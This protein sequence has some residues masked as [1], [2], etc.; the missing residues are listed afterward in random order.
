[1]KTNILCRSHPV[2]FCRPTWH[3]S[4]LSVVVLIILSAPIQADAADCAPAPAGMVAW[5]PG[6]GNADDIAS[7]NHGMLKNGAILAAGM[8]GQAFIFDGIGSYVQL[9][10]L[11]PGQAEG[12]VECW[13]KLN[14][15][16]WSSARDGVYL[17][18]STEYLPD[19]PNSFDGVNLGTHRGYTSTG[20]ELMFGVWDVNADWKWAMSGVI[21]QMGRWYHVAGTWGPNGVQ[22]YVDGVQRGINPYLGAAPTYLQ[23]SLLGR[24]SHPTSVTDGLIDEFA[25]FSRALSADEIAAIYNAG[26]A[27]KCK[28]TP[29]PVITAITPHYDDVTLTWTSLTNGMYRVEYALTVTGTNWTALTPYITTTGTT[30]SFTD[31]SPGEAPRYYRVVPISERLLMMNPAADARILENW[32]GVNEGGS[33]YLSVANSQ[34]YVERTLLQFDLSALGVNRVITKAIL[35]LYADAHLYPIGNPGGEIME[36]YRL[37]QPWAE[38]QVT[39]SDRTTGAPWVTAGGDY[40]GTTGLPDIGSYA[41]NTTV[42]ADR[43]FALSPLELDWNVT[44]LVQEWYGGSH[45][46]YGMMLLSYPENGLHFN[47]RESGRNIPALEV[48]IAEVIDD[49]PVIQTLSRVSDNVKLTWTSIPNRIYQVEYT[50]RLSGTNWTALTPNIT[51]TSNTASFTDNPGGTTERYYR[52]VLLP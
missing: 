43:F 5:W 12:T 51:A 40:V 27:G 47:S 48:Y 41:A 46:N 26:S 52:I 50:S 10:N 32:G 25:L 8:I 30:T 37:S 6:D 39:W 1:M 28:E 18:S 15:W 36:V 42:V 24:S 14:T 4:L 45:S 20:G 31:N 13:F 3:R 2:V 33:I 38:T 21:P 16:N 35:K 9:P 49:L 7:T 34:G 23:Y 17:W 22:I 19:S 29:V 44:S 11:I